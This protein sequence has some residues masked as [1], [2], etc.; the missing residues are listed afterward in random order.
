MYTLK[1]VCIVNKKN[2]ITQITKAVPFL[3]L[4]CILKSPFET[5]LATARLAGPTESDVLRGGPAQDYIA[6]VYV[7]H[8]C[9]FNA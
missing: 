4:I 2:S 6:L 1:N 7:A 3:D 5:A 8:T 9:M